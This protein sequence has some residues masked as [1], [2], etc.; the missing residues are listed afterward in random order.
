MSVSREIVSKNDLVGVCGCSC[1][2]TETDRITQNTQHART[3]ARTHS[4]ENAQQAMYTC[5]TCWHCS[6]VSLYTLPLQKLGPTAPPPRVSPPLKPVWKCAYLRNA[7]TT[8]T[9]TNTR[10]VHACPRAYIQTNIHAHIPPAAQGSDVAGAAECL[11]GPRLAP[12]DSILDVSTPGPSQYPGPRMAR[13]DSA[14]LLHGAAFGAFCGIGGAPP[15]PLPTGLV[16]KAGG[17]GA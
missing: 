7:G 3:H 9:N 10:I 5:C 1:L 16:A 11:A 13:R 17:G 14:V 4:A 8:H 15:P 2:R 6:V 12:R